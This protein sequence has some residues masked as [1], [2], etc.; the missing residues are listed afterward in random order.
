MVFS[1]FPDIFYGIYDSLIDSVCRPPAYLDRQPSNVGNQDRGIVF[2]H[3][4]GAQMEKIF[5]TDLASDLKDKVFNGNRFS[6][7]DIDGTPDVTFQQGDKGGGD[8]GHVEK[9]PDLVAMR[10]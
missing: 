1:V 8:I 10:A 3:S 2:P 6:R 9:I 5:T 4:N 7:G